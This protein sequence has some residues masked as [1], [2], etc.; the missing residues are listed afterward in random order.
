MRCLIL[1]PSLK[2]AG[3]ETQAV[4]LANGLARRG[5]AIH[6]CAFEPQLDQRNR[7]DDNVRFHHVTRLRKFDRSLPPRIATLIDQENIEIVLGVM[8]FAALI[9]VMASKRSKREPAVVPAIHTTTNRG[10]KEEIQDRLFYRGMLAR[11]PAVVFVCEFQRAYWIRKFPELAGHARVIYNGIDVARFQRLEFECRARDLLAQLGILP[12]SFVFACVAGFRKEKAHRLLLEAFRRLPRRAY[13]LLAGDGPERAAI[14]AMAARSGLNERV[15]FL[16]VVADPRPVIVASQATVLPSI[17]VETFSMA[18]LESMALA[19]PMIASD[20]GGMG[21][22][23]KHQKSG[24]LFPPKDCHALVGEMTFVME[25]PAA[26]ASLGVAARESV[27]ERFTLD[28]M[29]SGYESLFREILKLN[30]GQ[31]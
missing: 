24:L 26:A 27:A 4:D 9:A 18:M 15:K 29:V 12:D 23:I 30:N 16:G 19:V 8:Q 13:L 2:R 25:S 7:L 28:Q 5:H 21:E 31:S 17:A 1:L 22:A 10:V 3:A 11:A 14:Q 20:L 6:L